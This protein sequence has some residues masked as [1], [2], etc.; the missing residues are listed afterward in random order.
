MQKR[1]II[2]RSLL[3]VVTS[4]QDAQMI[5][6]DAKNIDQD[7]QIDHKIRKKMNINTHK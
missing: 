5:S 7:T 2:L 6:F 3:I 1:P 4:Y